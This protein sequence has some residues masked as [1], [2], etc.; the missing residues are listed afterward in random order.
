MNDLD[1]LAPISAQALD[2]VVG[3][4]A[5]SA[6]PVYTNEHNRV[7]RLAPGRPQELLRCWNSQPAGYLEC[8]DERSAQRGERANATW[9]PARWFDQQGQ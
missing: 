7:S 3:G 2:H 9:A 1:H 8:I 6:E 4:E 5:G